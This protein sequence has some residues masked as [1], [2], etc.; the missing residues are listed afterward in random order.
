M[1]PDSRTRLLARYV[2]THASVSDAA[3][4]DGLERRR[5]YLTKLIR[6]HF[7]VDR[8]AAIL[9]LGCGHGALL[10]M[11]RQ[12]GYDRLAGVDASPEQVAAAERLGIAGVQQGE[13]RQALAQTADESQDVVVLFDLFHYFSLDEQMGIADDV[14]RVLKPGGQWILHVPNGEALFGARMRYW[15][16]LATGAFTR[17]SIAQLLLTCGFGAVACFEDR[18]IPHGLKS[19]VRWG[20]WGAVRGISRL[21]LAAETGD[22]GRQAI[23]SQCLLAVAR[24]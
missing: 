5:A 11:A 22:T 24:K 15:D 8:R 2:S 3:A 19:A 14:R 23:F 7:P 21:V 13:L 20:L 9:D 18:P 1:T 10:W 16:L 6:D 17:A 4:R 12:M